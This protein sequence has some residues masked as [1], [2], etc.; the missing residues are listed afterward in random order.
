MLVCDVGGGSTQLAFGTAA[1][2]PHWLRS[3]DVGSL[4]L[5]TRLHTTDLPNEAVLGAWRAEVA[6]ELDR[7]VVP[8]PERAFAVGGTARALR[9]IAGATTLGG[10]DVARASRLL[11]QRSSLELASDFKLAP[12]RARTVAAGAVIVAELQLRVG[13]PLE[14]VPA[15]LREGLALELAR[16]R[17]PN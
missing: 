10:E 9:K 2:G 14:V 11:L 12:M 3:L 5:T 16:T 7:L 8:R 13:V 17:P 1:D 4:R 6:R 15:G